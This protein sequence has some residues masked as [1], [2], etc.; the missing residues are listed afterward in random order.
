MN[1]WRR[2]FSFTTAL[3][4]A[5]TAQ[6]AHAGD[7]NAASTS[8]AAFNWTGFYLGGDVGALFTDAHF[9]QPLPPGLPPAFGLVGLGDISI[10][11]IDRR[12]AWGTY[13]GY[14]YQPVSW[15]VVG[16]DANL[17][18][19]SGAFYRELGFQ[20]DFLQQARYLNS[21]TARGGL[22]IR[23]D[24]MVYAKVGPAVAQM[25][26]IQGLPPA[27]FQRDLW[28]IQG[29]VGIEFSRDPE[30]RRPGRGVL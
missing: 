10:G 12:P 20:F 13:F 14:N 1:R 30:Y 9:S 19:L 17:N 18:W 28:G 22:V 5:A 3:A 4:V 26:G 29:G 16:I 21:V 11:T 6:A 27:A 24:T 2:L 8:P 25:T 23:P 7:I 15:A